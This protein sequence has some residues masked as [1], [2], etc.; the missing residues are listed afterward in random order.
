MELLTIVR[1]VPVTL[2]ELVGEKMTAMLQLL[3]AATGVVVLQVVPVPVLNSLAFVPVTEK[4][5]ILKEALPVSLMLKVS[6][7]EDV[8]IVTPPKGQLVGL[9]PM[10]APV[11][12][13]VRV[14]G[15]TVSTGLVTVGLNDADRLF[16]S[17]KGVNVK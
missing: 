6:G 4:L 10:T 9:A 11:P 13:P 5:V 15:A 12:V 17:A 16:P 14:T 1:L 3:P 7:E 8:P 2:A